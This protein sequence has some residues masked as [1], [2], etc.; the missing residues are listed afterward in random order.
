MG[1]C[2]REQRLAIAS[3]LA[4]GILDPRDPSRVVY[5]LD[6]IV[7]TRM[8]IAAGDADGNDAD[9]LR[10]DPM[11]KL[12]LGRLPNAGDLCSQPTIS[13]MENPPDARALLY[14]GR[15]MIDRYCLG[16]RQVSRRI[17]LDIDDR[18]DAVHGDQQLRL[19][20]AH[21][22]EHGFQPV[23]VFDDD[24][25]IVAA[26]L[27]PVSR[28]SGKQIVRWLHRLITR[29]WDDPTNPNWAPKTAY[30]ATASS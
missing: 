18:F 4:G 11:F 27:R 24:G 25:R 13:R 19:F 2:S 6:E 23:V 12:A 22:D 14:M 9:A 1:D 28:L 16:F 26:V 10:R 5:G 29:H 21:H 7:R 3:R 17:V 20:N 8:L 15:A 30:E